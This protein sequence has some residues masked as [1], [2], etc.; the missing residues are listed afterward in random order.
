MTIV[1]SPFVVARCDASTLL[2]LNPK[3]EPWD[4][5]CLLMGVARR[6]LHQ[7]FPALMAAEAMIKALP[8]DQEWQRV[9]DLFGVCPLGLR[10]EPVDDLRGIDLRVEA[11]ILSRHDQMLLL[12][13]LED[14]LAAMA[15]D[16]SSWPKPAF[17][18][19]YA[20]ADRV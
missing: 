15:A 20:I 8:A 19:R 6:V 7:L 16:P 13:A 11:G 3:M 5:D 2:G 4:L 18:Q 17:V 1:A 12:D 10:I 9:D 14:V